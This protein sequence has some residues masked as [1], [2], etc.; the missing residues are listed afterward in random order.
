LPWCS[1]ET[2]HG[3]QNRWTFQ[4]TYKS[5]CI[6]PLLMGIVANQLMSRPD[7]SIGH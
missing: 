7:V 4:S 3:P 5:A 2:T 6:C 1:L